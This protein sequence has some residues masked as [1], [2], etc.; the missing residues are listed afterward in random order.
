MGKIFLSYCWEDHDYADMI[1]K[2]LQEKDIFVI[3]DR[4]DLKYGESIKEFTKKVRK[5]DYVIMVVSEKFL[6]HESCMSEVVELMKT[7]HYREKICPVI[8]RRKKD[9]LRFEPECMGQYADYWNQKV[10]KQGD[11]VNKQQNVTMKSEQLELCKLYEDIYQKIGEFLFYLKD[12]IYITNKELD[13][14]EIQKSGEKILSKICPLES[15]QKEI[16]F[17]FE[18]FEPGFDPKEPFEITTSKIQ[19]PYK[20][21]YQT[22]CLQVTSHGKK[23]F[24]MELGRGEYVFANLIGDRIIKILPHM[25][26]A[27][28]I[29]IGRPDL[30][31]NQIWYYKSGKKDHPVTFPSEKEI[32]CMTVDYKG[33]IICIQEGK[34]KNHSPNFYDG[35]EVLELGRQNFVEAYVYKTRYLLL[36]NKGK[37]IS[38]IKCLDGLSGIYKIGFYSS[39]AYVCGMDGK[40]KTFQVVK[41]EKQIIS[42]AELKKAIR[43]K[44]FQGMQGGA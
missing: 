19:N 17:S 42:E 21:V 36:T 2:Y 15:T 8:I 38:N 24:E 7:D 27:D 43:K 13:N 32:S 12:S 44:D 18:L 30:S 29:V 20:G 10:Q 6:H 9:E 34:I 16:P 23:E 22:A 3:L 35:L 25:A 39:L 1:D 11:L 4:R 26:A 28:S 33:G 40:M 41:E 37:T 14:G 5:S 31:K